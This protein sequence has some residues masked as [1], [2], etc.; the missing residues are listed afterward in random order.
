MQDEPELR[1]AVAALD[2]PRR[3]LLLDLFWLDRQGNP[4]SQ[5][6]RILTL[7]SGPPRKQRPG[8][9]QLGLAAVQAFADA[10]LS[11]SLDWDAFDWDDLRGSAPAVAYWF[12]QYGERVPGVCAR[13]VK[14]PSASVFPDVERRESVP[15]TQTGTVEADVVFENLDKY[16]WPSQAAARSVAGAADPGDPASSADPAVLAKALE[17]QAELVA[18]LVA[19]VQ[20]T[21]SRLDRQSEETLATLRTEVSENRFSVVGSQSVQTLRRTLAFPLDPKEFYFYGP[22]IHRDGSR[23]TI[24]DAADPL[25]RDKVDKIFFDSPLS[26]MVAEKITRR[27]LVP[28][29]VFV[30]AREYDEIKTASLGGPNTAASKKD[31]DLRIR[32]QTQLKQSQPLFKVISLAS[33]AYNVS[34]RLVAKHADPAESLDL[35]DQLPLVQSM[36]NAL[37]ALLFSASDCV[38]LVGMECSELENKRDDLYLQTTSGNP[39]L[40][41][42]RPKNNPTQ[43]IKD[44][45]KL[46]EIAG[47]ERQRRRE[48]AAAT[49]SRAT[50]P[51]STR[52][53]TPPPGRKRPST[54]ERRSQSQRDK[55]K[56]AA[57]KASSPSPAPAPASAPA[58]A[59]APANGGAAKK[60]KK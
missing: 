41:K 34:Q 5:Q 38:H 36:D 47:A 33:H 26:N 43:N 42:P 50:T 14:F 13:F 40:K 2:L 10:N 44:T 7:L 4:A 12:D 20:Q 57:S 39:F 48:L 27:S 22:E 52:G 56:H 15:S 25:S 11:L 30:S 17:P 18:Q 55:A 1:N 54:A 51:R 31:E 9:L 8:L 37:E 35:G 60:K 21:E 46:D 32:Q 23:D 49:G 3:R 45:T 59:P 6:K 58:A 53:A 16:V 24:C 19:R 28:E 29:D